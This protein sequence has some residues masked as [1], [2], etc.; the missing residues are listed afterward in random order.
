MST[1]RESKDVE[2]LVCAYTCVNSTYMTYVTMYTCI[3]SLPSAE[4]SVADDVAGA[5]VLED[6]NCGVPVADDNKSYE[7]WTC[8]HE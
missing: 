4:C 6:T 8:A 5:G 7:K 1:E 2:L 3:T